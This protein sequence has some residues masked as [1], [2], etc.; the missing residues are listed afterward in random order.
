MSHVVVFLLGTVPL[1]AGY[2][3]AVYFGFPP[4]KDFLFLGYLSNEK[5]SAVFKITNPQQQ[6]GRADGVP[7]IEMNSPITIQ[8]GISIEPINVID[9][10]TL[11]CQKLIEIEYS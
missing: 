6:T 5:P 2:G 11:S 8:L 10:V 9:Q 1:P 7:E 4:Y 3:A